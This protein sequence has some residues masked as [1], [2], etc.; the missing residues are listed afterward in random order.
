M[1]KSIGRYLVGLLVIAFGVIALLNN[2]A[3]TSISLGYVFSLLWPLLII[4]AGIN[5][6]INRR[7]IAGIVTGLII[8]LIGLAFLG[9]NAHL[10][11]FDMIYFWN[12]FWPAIIILI[13]VNIMAKSSQVHSSHF[14]VMGALEKKQ[15]G[16]E[17][18][19]TEYTALMGGIELDIRKASFTEKEISLTLTAIMGGINIFVP[20][21]I[22][23]TCNGTSILGGV[24]IKGQESGG[25]IGSI[26]TQVGDVKSAR[27]IIHIDCTCILGGIDIK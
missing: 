24:N 25:I 27:H 15:D 23:L 8:V 11:Y 21:D 14:A 12:I 16:W 3:V 6:L 2:F 18:K 1:P 22:A 26:S 17:L 19:S 4:T 7:D 5:F 20:D 9:R 13:G 10:F